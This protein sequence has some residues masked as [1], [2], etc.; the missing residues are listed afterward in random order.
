MADSELPADP[1]EGALGLKAE[2][3]GI[4]DQARRQSSAASVARPRRNSSTKPPGDHTTPDKG[5]DSGDATTGGLPEQV[6]SGDMQTAW[7]DSFLSQLVRHFRVVGSVSSR[8]KSTTGCPEGDALAVY[9]MAQLNWLVLARLERVQTAARDTE[10]VSYVDNWLYASYMYNHLRLNLDLTHK[11]QKVA[12]FKISP[13]KTWMSS[14]SSAA[15]SVM[16]TWSWEG[17]VPDVCMSK[18]ELG[19]LFRFSRSP[20]FAP[21]QTRWEQGLDRISCLI[22]KNWPIIRKVAVVNQGVFPVLF[23][24]CET[25]HASLSNLRTIRARLN[26]AVIGRGS[27]S[28]HFLSPLLASAET[29]EPFL[30]IFKNRLTSLRSCLV[31]FGEKR[32]VHSW[33]DLCHLHLPSLQQKILGPIGLFIWSCQILQWEVIT[34]FRVRVSD[35]V[36]LHL[37]A[38]PQKV[39]HTCVHQPW[40]EYAFKQFLTKQGHP[41][42]SVSFSVRTWKSMWARYKSLPPLSIKYRTFGILSPR[43]ELE[44]KGLRQVSANCVVPRRLVTSIPLRN[45]WLEDV[46][47]LPKYARIPSIPRFTRC[48]GVPISVFRMEDEPFEIWAS[49]ELV[50]AADLF[51]D[52]SASPTDLPN[53]RLSAWSVVLAHP[54][55]SFSVLAHGPSP[56]PFH[57]ILQAETYAVLVALRTTIRV[58]LFVDNSTVVNLLNRLLFSGFDPFQWVAGPDVDLWAAIAAE[59]ISRPPQFI[60]ITKVKSHSDP[61]LAS[62]CY[63]RWLIAGNAKADHWAKLALSDLTRRRPLWDSHKERQAF[64]RR[65]SFFPVST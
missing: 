26:V 32:A 13:S 43:L 18:V 65:V 1:L 39:W 27:V 50:P 17:R 56:G 37:L 33:N 38:T 31:S 36:T 46:R 30:Y 6:D 55:G 54:G 4:E 63:E 22:N 62:D 61:S 10:M 48:T 44:S 14:T 25:L 45:A 58:H 52:G 51:T 59:V 16:K 28:S 20:S 12:G 15:R 8:I 60:P 24:G 49:L 34:D 29:Y 57:N 2:E 64:S 42:T 23:S 9:Q 3:E 11:F 21:T 7:Y 53:V 19:M 40:A 41:F 35:R 47:Q 5:G